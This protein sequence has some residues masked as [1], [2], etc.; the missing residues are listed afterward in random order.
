MLFG[1]AGIDEQVLAQ[2][3]QYLIL[4][5]SSECFLLPG[6]VWG[7]VGRGKGKD[8]REDVKKDN[9]GVMCKKSVL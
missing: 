8:G 6:F 7:Q 3:L 2:C 5:P 9:I 4:I 1:Q